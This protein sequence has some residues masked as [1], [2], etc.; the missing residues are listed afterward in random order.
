[1]SGFD[2][3]Q[4]IPA[5][6]FDF[7]TLK[8]PD[9]KPYEGKGTIPE[10]PQEL[11]DEVMD[12]L[13]QLVAS[14]GIDPEILMSNDPA[15]VVSALAGAG[16]EALERISSAQLDVITKLCQGTPTREQIE[17]LPARPRQA[18]YGWLLGQFANPQNSNGATRP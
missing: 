13:R 2:A 15:K 8:G 9:G 14:L 10:P 1:M 3:G 5:L 18:F 17:A 11:I 12:E 7:T 4:A 16:E 6:D